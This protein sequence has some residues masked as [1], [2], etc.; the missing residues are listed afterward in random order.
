MEG[1]QMIIKM[2]KK[3]RRGKEYAYHETGD[4]TLHH[5]VEICKKRGYQFD[6]LF[7]AKVIGVDNG[8]DIRP[9]GN[10]VDELPSLEEANLIRE[11]GNEGT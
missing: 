7:E 11:E 1:K 6:A 4:V 5:A 2:K 10:L 9:I 8:F 3:G